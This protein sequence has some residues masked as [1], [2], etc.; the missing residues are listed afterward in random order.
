MKHTY[1]LAGLV[2]VSALG[3]LAGPTAQAKTKVTGHLTKTTVEYANAAKTATFKGQAS[4]KVKKVVLTYGNTKKVTAKVNR[5][6]FKI[7]KAF[8][9]YRTFKLYG[10]NQKGTRITKVYT[11]GAETYTTKTPRVTQTDRSGVM[12][13]LLVSM[14]VPSAS[15]VTIYQHDNMLTKQYSGGTTALF[16]LSGINATK[17]HLTVTAR[18]AGRKTS[19]TAII[20]VVKPG[21]ILETNY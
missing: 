10:T 20:P 5:Q 1:L 9:G 21:L 17:Y 8:T 19:P 11:Y 4:A 7:S 6:Q 15:V 18:Q 3:L 2:G 16:H 13:T 12:G 14:Q